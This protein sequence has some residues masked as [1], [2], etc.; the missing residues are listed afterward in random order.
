MAF[1]SYRSA[2]VPVTYRGAAPVTTSSIGVGSSIPLG[3]ATIGG[4]RTAGAPILSSA[5]T[6][7]PQ[8]TATVLP[9]ATSFVQPSYP[10]APAVAYGAPIISA[11]PVVAAAPVVVEQPTYGAP[12]T[13]PMTLTYWPL[14]AKGIAPAIALEVS[15]L[16]WQLGAAPGSKGT[17]DI[18][19]EWL[20]MKP[21]TSWGFLPNLETGDGGRIG[22][23]LAILQYLARCAPMLDGATDADIRISQELLHQS[24]E[25]YQKIAKNVPTTMDPNKDPNAFGDWWLGNDPTTHSNAQGLQVYLN[26]FENFYIS[27]GGAGGRFTSQGSTIGEIKLYAT[28]ACLILIDNEILRDYPNLLEFY[29]GWEANPAVKNLLDRAMGEWGWNQYFI[30]PPPA[31]G[32]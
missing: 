30:A 19:S 1:T 15:G 17:G 11:A 13:E 20:E 5:R 26:Q 7:L 28:L 12:Q 23:E 3:T 4:I 27:V 32:Q 9:Q 6:V 18:W 21:N 24:E 22:S 16:P 25:L 31:E 2:G 14:F 29:L 8:A 10:Y